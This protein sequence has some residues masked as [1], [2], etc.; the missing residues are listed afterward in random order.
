MHFANENLVQ[1]GK[2]Q[3]IRSARDTGQQKVLIIEDLSIQ[4]KDV[5]KSF[6]KK[7][8]R[9]LIALLIIMGLAKKVYIYK[10]TEDRCFGKHSSKIIVFIIFSKFLRFLELFDIFLTFNNFL[11]DLPLLQLSLSNLLYSIIIWPIYQLI[12]II[13]HLVQSIKINNIGE[14]IDLYI[15]NKY[16]NIIPTWLDIIYLWKQT[17]SIQIDN[18]TRKVKT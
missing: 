3:R 4:L 5:Y 11:T 8:N 2:A 9:V 18:L 14:N 15:F 12:I 1:K 13:D 6:G 10:Q 16:L 7:Y 17:F